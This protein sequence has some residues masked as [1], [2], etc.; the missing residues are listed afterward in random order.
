MPDY[1]PRI[2]ALYDEDNPD[3]PDHE[4]YRRLADERDARSI[5]DLGC[6]T[7]I[8][9]VTLATHGRRVVGVDPSAAMLVYARGRLGGQTVTW[10]HGDSRYVP[11]EGFDL[12]LMTGNV[13]QHISDADWG[14]TL[15]DLSRSLR[16]GGTLAFESRNPELR[17]WEN[18]ASSEKGSRETEHGTLV[19]WENVELVD[20]R[21]VKL[22]AHNL[23]TRTGDT[24]TIQEHLVFRSKAEIE[25]DLRTAG[26]EVEAV[27]GDWAMSPF[28]GAAPI[29]VFVATRTP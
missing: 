10:I 20:D 12:A 23:F 8:L 3:G 2:V 25:G 29:M 26:F 5:L 22:T 14:R 27:Y 11:Q 24:V 18:W 4:F 1:D 17:A 28:G 6:G 16:T 19:E 13:A 15:R 7:G 21:T 9:T